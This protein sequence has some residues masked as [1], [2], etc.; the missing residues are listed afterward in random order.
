MREEGRAGGGGGE[1]TDWILLSASLA[2]SVR[3][4]NPPTKKMPE[5]AYFVI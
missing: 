5:A 1:T 3:S 4:F 2:S